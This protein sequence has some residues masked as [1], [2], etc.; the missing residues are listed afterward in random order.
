[1]RCLLILAV[2]LLLTGNVYSQR[3][4]YT[5]LKEQLES[6]GYDTTK[7]VETYVIVSDEIGQE[8]VDLLAPFFHWWGTPL[9][10]VKY[11]LTGKKK[12]F[13]KHFSSDIVNEHKQIFLDR[14]GRLGEELG[15]ENQIKII[16]TMNDRIL[17]EVLIGEENLDQELQYMK[18]WQFGYMNF[19]GVS[20]TN[21]LSI[22]DIAPAINAT[23][24]KGDKVCLDSLRGKIIVLNFWSDRCSACI[25]EMPLLNRLSDEYKTKGVLFFSIYLDSI[26]S[27]DRYFIKEDHRLFGKDFVTFPIIADAMD[28]VTDYDIQFYPFT[29]IVGP[30]GTIVKYTSFVTY[31]D[32]KDFTYL[33]LKGALERL[34][35]IKENPLD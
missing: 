31:N 4:S 1:M 8:E 27:L 11:I 19:S 9:S 32:Q 30:S 7:M 29:Y 3:F 16:Y 35:A 22:G 20:F 21:P 34:I 25:Y 14:E 17:K 24:T 26:T 6:I 2:A 13:E 18:E 5:N 23:T 28:I 12:R 33:T 10:H 15:N